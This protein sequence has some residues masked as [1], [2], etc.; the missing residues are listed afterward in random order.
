ML[1]LALIGE[2]RMGS[3]VVFVVIFVELCLRGRGK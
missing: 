3:E 1:L 2:K